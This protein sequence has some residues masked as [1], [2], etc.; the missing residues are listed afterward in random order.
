MTGKL[1]KNNNT[2]RWHIIIDE[3]QPDHIELTSGSVIE[4]KIGK[5]WVATRIEFGSKNYYATTQ[6][7]LLCNNLPART[8]D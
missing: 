6:G 7:V 4:V 3:N 1:L 8:I 5:H 2:E